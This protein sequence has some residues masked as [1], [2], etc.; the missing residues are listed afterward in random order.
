MK[1]YLKFKAVCT[2]LFEECMTW[3]NCYRPQASLL[4]ICVCQWSE[5]KVAWNLLKY[6]TQEGLSKYPMRI[7]CGT[8]AW[9]ALKNIIEETG[10]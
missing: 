10:E 4:R 8:L 9:H 1:I 2:L 7:K 6:E 5:W 3:G